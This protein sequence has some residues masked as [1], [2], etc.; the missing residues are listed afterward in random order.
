MNNKYFLEITPCQTGNQVIVSGSPDL[1][2]ACFNG[3]RSPFRRFK[4]SEKGDEKYIKV[5]CLKDE[6]ADTLCKN[7]VRALSNVIGLRGK[8]YCNGGDF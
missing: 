7:I 8:D 4:F 6:T 2:D 3:M 1:V 5:S